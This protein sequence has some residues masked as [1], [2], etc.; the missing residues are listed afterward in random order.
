MTGFIAPKEDEVEADNP[1]MQEEEEREA[2]QELGSGAGGAAGDD[3][4]SEAPVTHRRF[5][6]SSIGLTVL[7]PMEVESIEARVS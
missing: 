1:V 6:P 5:L 7:V 3:E 2:E 4:P